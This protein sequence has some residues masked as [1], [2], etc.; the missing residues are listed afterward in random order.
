MINLKHCY[1]QGTDL[2]GVM[3]HAHGEEQFVTLEKPTVK[4]MGS[5]LVAD[6][7][8]ER[9]VVRGWRKYGK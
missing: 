9:Y 1:L 3:T 2:V 7:E 6:S 4:I 5:A 8:G